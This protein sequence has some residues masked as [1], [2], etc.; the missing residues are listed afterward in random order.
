MD[1]KEWPDVLGIG[2]RVQVVDSDGD[3]RWWTCV[4]WNGHAGD[5]GHLGIVT[6]AILVL[7]VDGASYWCSVV[8]MWTEAGFG[9]AKS[10]DG[11]P[12]RSGAYPT[13]RDLILDAE[14]IARRGY[15]LRPPDEPVEMPPYSYRCFDVDGD[16]TPGIVVAAIPE[17][18]QG[19]N[20]RSKMK[21][22]DAPQGSVEW[23]EARLGRPTASEADA[24]MARKRNGGTAQETVGISLQTH[25][26]AVHRAAAGQSP[27]RPCSAGWTWSPWCATST[28]IGSWWRT[29]DAGRLRTGR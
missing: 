3:S 27:R 2:D 18:D 24:I 15:A 22:I 26:R 25:R 13:I 17:H 23:L 19:I 11:E 9:L 29:A 14:D 28:R 16:G 21:I 8:G 12:L 4:G 10:G 7:I 6:Q 5:L 20:G 1:H